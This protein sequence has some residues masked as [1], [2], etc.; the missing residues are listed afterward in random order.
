MTDVPAQVMEQIAADLPSHADQLDTDISNPIYHANKWIGNEWIDRLQKAAH[1]NTVLK[2]LSNGQE[3]FSN[4]GPIEV[5]K[6]H[7]AYS[8][9]GSIRVRVRKGHQSD[10]ILLIH[11]NT[12][13]ITI[14]ASRLWK[15]D[16]DIIPFSRNNANTI[17]QVLERQ[18][19]QYRHLI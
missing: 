8:D 15:Q 4:I 7:I 3:S 10:E 9:Q 18:L 16:T 19:Q 5:E 11:I 1:A 14:N 6:I 12:Y 13:N 17:I 2:Q